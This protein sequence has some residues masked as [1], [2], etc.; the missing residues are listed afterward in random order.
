MTAKIIDGVAISASI[1]KELKARV[2]ALGRRGTVPGLAV[3][4]AGNDPASA[5]YVRNKIR[6]CAQ[7]GIQSFRS[8]DENRNPIRPSST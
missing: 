4:V 7:I 3:I 8:R 6:A 1:R 2:E 5:V